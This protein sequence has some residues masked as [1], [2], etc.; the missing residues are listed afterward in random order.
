MTAAEAAAYL[1]EWLEG[2]GRDAQIIGTH[3]SDLASRSTVVRILV[4]GREV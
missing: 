1:A 2:S 4:E 3:P